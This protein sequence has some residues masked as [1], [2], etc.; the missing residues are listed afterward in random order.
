M[1][2]SGVRWLVVLVGALGLI[3]SAA[4]QNRNLQVEVVTPATLPVNATQHNDV[5]S[6]LVDFLHDRGLQC[7]AGSVVGVFGKAH[8]RNPSAAT[9]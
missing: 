1:N 4:A 9:E 6:P 7:C 5:Q 3:V 2:K 8:W